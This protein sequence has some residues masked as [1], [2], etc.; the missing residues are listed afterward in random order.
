MTEQKEKITYLNSSGGMIIFER[1]PPYVLLEKTGF[2]GIANQITSEKLFDYDGEVEQNSSLETRSLGIKALVYGESRA[3]DVKLR[4]N[5]LSVFN[6]K[7]R[8]KLTYESYGKTYEIEVSITNGWEENYDERSGTYQGSVS[9]KALSPLWK[10]VSSDSYIVQLGQTVNLLTFP[11]KITDNFEFARTES[12][13]EVEVINPGHIPIGMEVDIECTAEV[14]NPK[15]YNL[16]T[17]E[18]FAFNATFKGGDQIYLN[19]NKGEK[20][21]LINGENGFFK[22]KLGSTFL[23]ISH[24]ETNYFVLQAERGVENMIATMKYHPLLTGVC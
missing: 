10:D 18:Y 3:E 24:L 21:V 7:L 20:Q 23:Q 1:V 8:G 17:E 5:L 13:R 19:T 6:P 22:R 12:G 14:I 15:I 11:L 4:R 16:Y 9:F 2:G